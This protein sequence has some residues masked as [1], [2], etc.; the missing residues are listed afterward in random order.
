MLT[1]YQ[2]LSTPSIYLTH[3]FIFFTYL[4]GY[5][6][7]WWSDWLSSRHSEG[8]R[9]CRCQKSD[10]GVCVY[11]C[12]FIDRPEPYGSDSGNSNNP[13]HSNTPNNPALC[14][15]VLFCVFSVYLLWNCFGFCVHVLFVFFVLLCFLC[16][17]SKCCV[18]RL[19]IFNMVCIFCA[20]F[21]IFYLFSVHIS[22]LL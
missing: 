5:N 11:R 2:H 17:F 19:C 3:L 20:H 10:Q 14:W 12:T 13:N 1:M 6:L 16:V 22:C 21:Y 7:P 15:R 8:I 9:G 18:W 4:S